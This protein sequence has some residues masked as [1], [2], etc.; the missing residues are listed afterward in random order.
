MVDLLWAEWVAWAVLS[1]CN[2]G[3]QLAAREARGVP[4]LKEMTMGHAVHIQSREQY[5][6]ALGVLDHVEGT[7]RGIGPSSA[8]VL[9]L[10][11]KQYSDL[12]AAQEI[13]LFEQVPVQVIEAAELS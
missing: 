13:V 2:R 6:A 7:W 3:G 4:R 12:V 5:I 9:L 11:D 10:T 8:P 1:A